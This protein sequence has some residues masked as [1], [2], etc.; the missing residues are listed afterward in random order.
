MPLILQH[1][2]WGM[3]AKTEESGAGITSWA[4]S[5]GFISVTPQGMDDNMNYGGPWYS[6]NAVGTTQSPGAAGATCTAA[7][8][9]PSYCYSSCAPCRDSPQCDWT[10]CDE[11]VTPTGTGRSKV[12]GFIP[13]LYDTLES[14]LC[15]DT[16]REYAAGESNG[17]MM[18]YQLGVDLASRL[19]AIAPQFGS[20]HRGFA[21]APEVGVPVID[22]HGTRDTTV[23]ANVSLSG[24]G[25]YYTVT[26][27]IFGGSQYSTG[28]KK[29]N[30]CQGSVSH[31]PTNY[32]GIQ[33]LWCGVEGT[34]FG[35]DVVFCSY[36]GGHTWF[37]NG[38]PDN[39]GLVTDFLLRWKKASHIGGGY[40]EGD[41]LG[42]G[43]VLEDVNVLGDNLGDRDPTAGPVPQWPE[44]LNPGT[45]HRWFE[46][47]K[48][49]Y[50]NPADG[51]LEDEDVLLLGTGHACAPRIGTEPPEIGDEKLPVPKCK[52]GGVAPRTNG[53]PVDADVAH[54][55]A[56]PICLAKGKA[57][58]PYR[59]GDFHCL[60]VCPCNLGNVSGGECG[61]ESHAHCPRG[62]RCERGELRKM[63]QGVCTYALK[64]SPNELV[65]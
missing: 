30:G 51:C 18:T 37:N 64:G 31:Y 63:D 45:G 40:S 29:A 15:I 4:E 34:C 20:F 16:T 65:V 53:C 35:G 9:S 25:Y 17:G 52:L 46:A 44:T 56:W 23:P 28:W 19:A 5:K 3:N 57:S 43:E 7:A 41:D 33:S 58:D 61:S 55:M 8:N 60:L 13:G 32:D 11:T 12:G 14:Q 10:T 27:Q 49:H 50:G 39:G 21:M 36:T 6:W 54:S 47:G 48:G 24:D 62:A 59:H 22:L 1:P 42:P 2:G 38:G 26:S